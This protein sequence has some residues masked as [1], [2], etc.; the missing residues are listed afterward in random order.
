MK[1]LQDPQLSKI[2]AELTD[3]PVG[4]AVINGRMEAFIMTRAKGDK[5]LAHVLG[6]RFQQ[7]ADV[8]DA[9]RATL[10]S[11]L[12]QFKLQL[13]MKRQK[14]RCKTVPPPAPP[15][16]SILKQRGGTRSLDATAAAAAADL[17]LHQSCNRKLMTDLILT[18]N[19][20]FP[21]YDF[22]SVGPS[23]FTHFGNTA[24]VIQRINEKLADWADSK[25]HQLPFLSSSSAASSSSSS[26]RTHSLYFPRVV[27]SSSDYLIDLWNAV[28]Q[29][30]HLQEAE[31]YSYAPNTGQE[32]EDD[33]MEFLIQSLNPFSHL[34][35]PLWTMNYFFVNKTRK[36]IVFF[37]SVSSMRRT[38]TATTTTT[39]T[40]LPSSTS[41]RM[42]TMTTLTRSTCG[43][44][45]GVQSQVLDM[46]QQQEDDD[47]EEDDYDYDESFRK[48]HGRDCSLSSSS[49]SSSRN[50]S[51]TC[52]STSST[53]KHLKRPRRP[54]L[55]DGDGGSNDGNIDDEDEED[56]DYDMEDCMTQA[57]SI[58]T[59]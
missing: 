27:S 52:S 51:S 53:S 55:V 57:V 21:D 4:S 49:S 41:S 43:G 11:T 48:S 25:K 35:L 42:E 23:S 13:P 29:V 37:T 16:K 1:F 2:T 5:R 32:D 34:Y 36:R 39:T 44:G 20:S 58:P 46:Q 50:S 31:V 30:I 54:S 38:T 24:L 22:S 12:D 14:R 19:A 8:A 45:G 10:L 59:L 6:E 9:E 33:P 28:D 17:D 26:S 18:L 47:D 56:G 40:M 3:A 15:L 7:Q